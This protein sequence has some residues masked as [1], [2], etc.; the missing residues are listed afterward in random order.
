MK[1]AI[2]TDRYFLLLT[3]EQQNSLRSISKKARNEIIS[4]AKTT[5]KATT[6][7]LNKYEPLVNCLALPRFCGRLWLSLCI[8]VI[9]KEIN[10]ND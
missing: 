4:L 5:D 9:D 2:S 3:P 8:H 6:G 10:N 7:I 1:E